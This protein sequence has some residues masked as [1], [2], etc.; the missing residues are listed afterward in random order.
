MTKRQLKQIIKEV[1]S[2]SND[3]L[4]YLI[5]LNDESNNKSIEVMV[6]E[7]QSDDFEDAL[8]YYTDFKVFNYDINNESFKANKQIQIRKINDKIIDDIYKYLSK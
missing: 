1:I 7:N 6:D 8:D 4:Y 2:E 5:T 3:K